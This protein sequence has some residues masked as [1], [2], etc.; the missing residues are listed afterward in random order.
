MATHTNDEVDT[1]A[2]VEDKESMYQ[3]RF[4]QHPAKCEFANRQ[5]VFKR[6]N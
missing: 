1:L 5:K 4:I 3:E 6:N 2:T